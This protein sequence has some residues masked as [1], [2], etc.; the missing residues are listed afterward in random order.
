MKKQELAAQ[1]RAKAKMA[2]AT[3]GSSKCEKTKSKANKGKD[4]KNEGKSKVK[5]GKQ[6]ASKTKASKTKPA[7]KDARKMKPSAYGE[8]KALFRSQYTG[9][10]KF[11]EEVW[12]GSGVCQTVLKSMSASELKRR[13]FNQW[14]L[15]G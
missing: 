6:T 13:R 15:E 4:R 8:A 1:R 10:R 9:E 2:A 7:K 14:L 12:C 3:A 11:I 5:K